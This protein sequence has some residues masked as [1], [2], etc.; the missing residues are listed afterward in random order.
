MLNTVQVL[1]AQ[2]TLLDIQVTAQFSSK[3]I[4]EKFIL[5]NVVIDLYSLIEKLHLIIGVPEELTT[6]ESRG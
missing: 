1:E 3:N 4:Q 5:D 2:K 6:P